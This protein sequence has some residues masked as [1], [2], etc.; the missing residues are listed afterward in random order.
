MRNKKACF[1]HTSLLQKE[2]VSI[3]ACCGKYSV[4]LCTCMYTVV[5]TMYSVCKHK[6]PIQ[7][8]TEDQYT[9]TKCTCKGP[10]I[11][12]HVVVSI[13]CYSLHMDQNNGIQCTYKGPMGT[14]CMYNYRDTR[15]LCVQRTNPMPN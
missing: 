5:D 9:R 7:W 1:L 11:Y 2:Y 4:I 12:R 8:D 3:L 10:I 13:L 14:Q 15:N 6:G